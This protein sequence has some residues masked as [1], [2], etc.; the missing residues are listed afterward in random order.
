MKTSPTSPSYDAALLEKLIQPGVLG[1]FNHVEITSV[2]ATHKPSKRTVNVLTHLVTEESTELETSP[3]GFLPIKFSKLQDYSFCITQHSVPL[4]ALAEKL[5]DAIQKQQWAEKKGCLKFGTLLYQGHWFVPPAGCRPDAPVNRL[6]KNNFWNGSHAWEWTP[7]DK[8]VFFPFFEKPQLL[9]ALSDKIAEHLPIKLASLSDKLGNL[10]LQ[11]PVT[12]LVSDYHGTG[13][14]QGDVICDVEWRPDVDP[15]PLIFTAERWNDGRLSHSSKRLE[16][17][18]QIILST[19]ESPGGVKAVIRDEEHDTLL[20]AIEVNLTNSIHLGIGVIH[21]SPRTFTIVPRKADEA[22][23]V[24]SIQVSSLQESVVGDPNRLAGYNDTQKRL[25]SE[26]MKLLRERREF[27]QYRSDDK[28]ENGRLMESEQR[29]SRA[30]KDVHYLIDKH[31][32]KAV[33][34][35]DPYLDAADILNTLFYN[36]HGGAKMRALSG[37]LTVKKPEKPTNNKPNC[38][39]EAFAAFKKCRDRSSDRKKQPSKKEQFIIKEHKILTQKSG[40]LEALNLEFRA[41]VGNSGS[42]FHDRFLIFPYAEPT[43]LAWSLGISV[44][45]L[46]KD[47]HIL[48]KVLNAQPIADAFQDLWDDLNKPEQLVWKAP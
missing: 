24:E 13:N 2:L 7:E 45:S 18:N 47:H 27:I 48:Q 5:N 21:Q 31:G 1:V 29:H 14:P 44:N 36:P 11:V 20:G 33:W 19:Q 37:A 28:D 8:S 41:R 42:A 26:E 17:G 3:N 15:R 23:T 34:L 40:N 38:L 32:K 46:G 25:Y 30:L 10:I 9:Q 43:P 4:D 6:L 22:G 35:W 39:A 16:G 12:C